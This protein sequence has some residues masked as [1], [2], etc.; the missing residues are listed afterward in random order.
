M[1]TRNYGLITS[2]EELKS[3]VDRLL[4]GD[5][6]IGFDIETGYTGP[7]AA[8][9]AVHPETAII[10]GLSIT[11]STDWARYIPLGHDTGENI[12]NQTAASLLWPVLNS[13]RGVAHNAS[14]ELRHLSRWFA[15]LLPDH[16]DVQQTRGYFPIRSCTLVESYVVAELQRFGLK[17]VVKALFDHDMTE[18]YDLFPGLPI[19]RRKMLR[20]NVLDPH[21]PGVFS[22]ACEDAAW[23][24]AIHEHYHHRIKDSL[25]YRV[26]MAVL[27]CV[28]EAEDTGVVYDWPFLRRA[29]EEVRRFRDRY[30]AEIM[31]DLSEMLG[32]PV[33]IDLAKPA[34][35]STV[36]YTKLG[37]TTTVYTDKTRDLPAGQRKMSTGKIALAGLAKKHPVVKKIQNW[38]EQ[39]RLLGTY[40]DRYEDLYNYAADG[41]AHPNILSS[42]VIT[43]RFAVSDPPLQQS[44]KKYHFDLAEA[45][46]VHKAHEDAHG[47]K[48]GCSEFEPPAGTC[49]KLNFRD[50]I[51]AP[52][53]H[54]ILGFDLSQAELRAIAGEAKEAALLSAFE[55]G[56]DVH[57]LTAALMLGI[58]VDDVTSD[59]RSIGKTMNFALLYGMGVKSLADRLGIPVGEAQALYDSYFRVYAGIAAWSAQQVKLGKAQG[60]VTSRFGRR[61]PIWEYQSDKKWIREKGDRACVN[62]PIQGAATGDYVRIAMVRARRAIQ[63]AGLADKMHFCMNIH[64][65][66]EWYVDVSVPLEQAIGVLH[67]AVIFP[68][69]GWP[70]M[71][72][73]WHVGK[74]WGSPTD[75]DLLPDGTIVT[76]SDTPLDLGPV[77]EEDD[78]GTEMVTFS[79]EDVQAVHRVVVPAPSIVEQERRLV[80]QVDDMPDTGGYTQFL[81]YLKARPGDAHLTL[82]TPEGDHELDGRYAIASVDIGAVSLMLGPA[83]ISREV[84]AVDFD[85]ILTDVVL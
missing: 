25:I 38:K 31:R 81:A 3:L 13:G 30:N 32:E 48:C 21:D 8:K 35:I 23:C 69:E 41:R 58:P 16:A 42:F 65:A 74:R 11:D 62:Y 59:Q 64:D 17:P 22:Y 50:A 19:N 4:G 67:E 46:A 5:G 37:L 79:D 15:R 18:L 85:T 83:R 75:I 2:V 71:Q 68:V 45:A 33:A 26:D 7:D 55:N 20:F 76:K 56:E 52:P 53:H 9:F 54:Y 78:D 66:L 27:E 80:I 12:D 24:L 60:F 39:T 57:R 44:P 28:C 70:M 1:A 14:F 36:L 34:H 61:L 73:D 51:T 63:S 49:F 47:S 82:R 77:I 6:P 10:A 43:G 29:A 84:D 72:A 40:L